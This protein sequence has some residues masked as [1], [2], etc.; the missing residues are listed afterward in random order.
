MAT[1]PKLTKK[2]TNELEGRTNSADGVTELS[3]KG[4]EI[5]IYML[6]KLIF[7]DLG[8]I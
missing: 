8:E 6:T 7:S 4:D 5:S 1:K 2:K 3:T